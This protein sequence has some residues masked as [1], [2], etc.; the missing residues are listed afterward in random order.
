MLYRP[1]GLLHGPV[2]S[3]RCVARRLLSLSSFLCYKNPLETIRDLGSWTWFLLGTFVH[4]LGI[5]EMPDETHIT[6]ILWM[7]FI[8]VYSPQF[9]DF[10]TSSADVYVGLLF[11]L[12][13]PVTV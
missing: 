13:T 4:V 2:H 12:S 6:G 7:G 9:L 3:W 5:L 11:F 8:N 10:D 1:I